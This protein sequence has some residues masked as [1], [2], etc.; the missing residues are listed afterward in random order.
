M[1]S[2]AP[3]VLTLHVVVTEDDG[4]WFARSLEIDYAAQGSSWLEVRKAFEDGFVATI[5]AH[6]EK[7]GNLHHF[8]R[9]APDHVFETYHKA[10]QPIR[11]ELSSLA[12]R[13]VRE[14]QQADIEYFELAA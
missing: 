13:R 2:V 1:T 14:F 12:V 9:P 6:I 3:I 4:R 11:N 7:Y 5:A 10:E 8:L